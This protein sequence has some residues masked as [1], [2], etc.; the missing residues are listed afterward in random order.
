MKNLNF[1]NYFSNEENK[2]YDSRIIITIL[3]DMLGNS[4]E[5][6]KKSINESKIVVT[7]EEIE[8]FLQKKFAE[9]EPEV[10]NRLENPKTI[11]SGNIAEW[12]EQ[13]RKD[14]SRQFADRIHSAKYSFDPYTLE[15]FEKYTTIVRNKIN[16]LLS[17][18]EKIGNKD[19]SSIEEVLSDLDIKLDD[20]GNILKNDIIRLI[21]PTVYNIKTFKSKISEANN[22]DT[23]LTFKISKDYIYRNGLTE[24][25]FYPSKS[26]QIKSIYYDNLEGNIRLSENQRKEL[27]EVDRKS[28]EEFAKL[29]MKI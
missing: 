7:K 28:E 15:Y 19:A 14:A 20:N 25:E 24:G 10:K 2:Y 11:R 3:E 8:D 22:L 9:E 6:I 5:E 21:T 13:D 12:T 17:I 4:I 23:Y 1:E 29:I 26:I 18:I 27:K 16:L